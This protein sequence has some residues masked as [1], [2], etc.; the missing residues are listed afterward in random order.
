MDAERIDIDWGDLD[1]YVEGQLILKI[2]QTSDDDTINLFLKGE[3]S[4]V[5]DTVTE[6]KQYFTHEIIVDRKGGLKC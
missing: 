1:V 4:G 5:V 2:G 3:G 6:D